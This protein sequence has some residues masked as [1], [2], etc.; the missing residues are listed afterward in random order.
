MRCLYCGIRLKIAKHAKVIEHCPECSLR[1]EQEGR[2]ESRLLR[3]E[4]K[5]RSARAQ[6]PRPLA[7][8]AAMKNA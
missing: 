5:N 7:A 3:A 2:Q 8:F 1:M 4:D 6:T